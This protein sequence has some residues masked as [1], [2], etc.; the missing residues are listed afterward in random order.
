MTWNGAFK[1]TK[2]ERWR[3]S[4][5][6]MQIDLLVYYEQFQYVEDAI[7]REKQIKGWRREKKR[8]LIESLNPTWKDLGADWL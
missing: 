7:V 1:S 8:A 3:A 5:E 4:L 2:R 6:S